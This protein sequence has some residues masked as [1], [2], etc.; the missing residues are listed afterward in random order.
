MF[1]PFAIHIYRRH[2]RGETVEQLSADLGIAPER[3]RIR[4]RAAAE[5]LARHSRNAA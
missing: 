5:Y 4:L 1:E 2:L 3:I